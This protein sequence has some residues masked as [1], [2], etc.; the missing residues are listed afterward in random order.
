MLCY[1]LVSFSGAASAP[2]VME[3]PTGIYVCVNVCVLCPDNISVCYIRMCAVCTHCMHLRKHVMFTMCK[4][5]TSATLSRLE[6]RAL[7]VGKKAC[8]NSSRLDNQLCSATSSKSGQMPEEISTI[9]KGETTLEM[10]WLLCF[11]ACVRRKS[12]RDRGVDALRGR[13]ERER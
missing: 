12:E 8:S 9:T 6:G 7:V 5:Q 4:N 2:Q 13:G 10:I 11:S 3:I 1:V